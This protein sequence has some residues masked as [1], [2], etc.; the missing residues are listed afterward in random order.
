MDFFFF[1]VTFTEKKKHP[2]V[3]TFE[4]GA[5]KHTFPVKIQPGNLIVAHLKK[6]W[7]K[8]GGVGEGS[9]MDFSEIEKQKKS[10]IS[11]LANFA[12]SAALGSRVREDTNHA[13]NS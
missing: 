3:R 4:I 7:W 5:S 10:Q 9:I 11:D 12:T 2:V 1:N 13:A 8:T 6:Q